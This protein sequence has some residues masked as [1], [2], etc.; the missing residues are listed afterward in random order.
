MQVG[1]AKKQDLDSMWLT[2]VPCLHL[3]PFSVF[4]ELKNNDNLRFSAVSARVLMI[5][6][7]C[8]ALLCRCVDMQIEF[9]FGPKLSQILR[10]VNALGTS[11]H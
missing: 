2:T 8:A 11:N 9:L 6:E 3:P 7:R 4:P 5:L 10:L 1:K